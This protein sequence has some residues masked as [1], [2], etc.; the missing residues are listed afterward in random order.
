MAELYFTS[1]NHFGHANIIRYCNRPFSSV[2]EMSETM[3]DRWNERVK[4]G[5]TVYHIGDFALRLGVPEVEAIIRR[6]N[7]DKHL[8]LGN[9]DLK[10]KSVL[11]AKGFVEQ[12][13]YKELKVDAQ[14]KIILCHYPFMTWNGSHRGSWDL[15]G[16]CHGSL[17]PRMCP[18][19]RKSEGEMTARRIDVGVDCWNFFPVSLQEVKEK[20]DKVKFEPVDH[21]EE[22]L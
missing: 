22:D 11:R 19:C 20:M 16:H 15:H 12:V 4:H 2:E 13:Y 3:I 6:L 10:N 8:V 1:D 9:H 21:H 7:G 18:F 14:Q 17:K 5:D